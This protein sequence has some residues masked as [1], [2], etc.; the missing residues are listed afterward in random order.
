[1]C[2][3]YLTCVFEIIDLDMQKERQTKNTNPP[4][5][6]GETGHKRARFY[7]NYYTENIVLFG[8]NFE[9]RILINFGS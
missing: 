4:N 3:I 1:V 9:E 5:G 6:D 2:S 7:C 8:L